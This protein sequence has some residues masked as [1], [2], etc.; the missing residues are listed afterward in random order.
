M[1]RGYYRER[2]L[3]RPGF[4]QLHFNL[5]RSETK[6]NEGD[7]VYWHLSVMQCL[8]F[9]YSRYGCPGLLNLSKMA[10][11]NQAGRARIFLKFELH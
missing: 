4:G 9:Q 10:S 6:S 7:V 3:T 1:A 5:S 2:G 8:R 11:G